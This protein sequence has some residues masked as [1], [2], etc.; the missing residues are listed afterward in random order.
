MLV[1]TLSPLSR[2][3]HTFQ[4]NISETFQ[5]NISKIHFCFML[6]CASSTE[7]R[8]PRGHRTRLRD[9]VKISCQQ[10]NQRRKKKLYLTLRILSTI[11]GEVYQTRRQ[12]YQHLFRLSYLILSPPRWALGSNFFGHHSV[13]YDVVTVL[14]KVVDNRGYPLSEFFT[15]WV[16][17][18]VVPF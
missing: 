1:V 9:N 15:L 13:H 17:A 18:T 5:Q 4:Q 12:E 14:A 7:F 16:V 3:T 10:A 11:H 8:K 2:L 6:T